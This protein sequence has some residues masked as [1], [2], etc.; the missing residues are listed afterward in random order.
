MYLQSKISGM[1]LDK[2]QKQNSYGRPHHNNINISI[3]IMIDILTKVSMNKTQSI[4][5]RM[6]GSQKKKII[7]I[8][9]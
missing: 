4:F 5:V 9:Y 7:I 6:Y 2:K 3:I 1:L 8:L